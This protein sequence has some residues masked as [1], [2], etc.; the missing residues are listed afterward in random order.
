MPISLFVKLFS[1]FRF[2][3]FWLIKHVTC[4]HLVLF[5]LEYAISSFVQTIHG[6]STIRLLWVQI[7]FGSRLLE[8]V[9][10]IRSQY[11]SQVM[12]KQVL[13]FFRHCQGRH[14]N[15]TMLFQLKLIFRKVSHHYL[16]FGR[17]AFQAGWN[18]FRVSCFERPPPKIG[19]DGRKNI[20]IFFKF[21][22]P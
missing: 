2:F 5:F 1:E 6:I 15:F 17:I 16:I 11:Q 18:K 4:D 3:L 19:S 8:V 12:L 22:F 13:I 7:C 20:Y 21:F 10:G 14:H 9:N